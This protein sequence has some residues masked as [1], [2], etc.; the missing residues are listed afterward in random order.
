[1]RKD[2]QNIIDNKLQEI[3][4]IVI[5]DLPNYEPEPDFVIMRELGIYFNK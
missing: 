1:M 4:D 2:I 3:I 5:T